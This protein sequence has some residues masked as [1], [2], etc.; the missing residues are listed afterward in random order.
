MHAIVGTWARRRAEAADV[1]ISARKALRLLSTSNKV[2]GYSPRLSSQVSHL[3][4]TYPAELAVCSEFVDVEITVLPLTLP[5]S[6]RVA[7]VIH[8]WTR[9]AQGILCEILWHRHHSCWSWKIFPD[10]QITRRDK[11]HEL[12]SYVGCPMAPKEFI[13]IDP[14]AHMKLCLDLVLTP[15]DNSAG[16]KSICAV[17][18]TENKCTTVYV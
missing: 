17:V 5:N 6:N 9:S 2:L 12:S 16:I 18:L 10:V 7:D 14:R 15:G 8:G 1:G 13:L 3:L 4:H 11:I